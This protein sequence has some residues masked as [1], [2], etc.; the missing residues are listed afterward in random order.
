MRS[1]IRP[2]RNPGSSH[3]REGREREFRG[4]GK[5]SEQIPAHRQGQTL[6][7]DVMGE[8]VEFLKTEEGGIGY[9]I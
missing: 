8:Y 3:R 6:A 2:K 5:E 4:A 9:G 1:E 7:L